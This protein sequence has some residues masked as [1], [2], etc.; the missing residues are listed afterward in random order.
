MPTYKDLLH[1]GEIIFDEEIVK[2]TFT[3]VTVFLY[4]NHKYTVTKRNGLVIS[5]IEEV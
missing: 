5:I 2:E 4:D 3:R 1:Y